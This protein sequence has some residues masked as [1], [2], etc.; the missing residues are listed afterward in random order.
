MKIKELIIRATEELKNNNVEDANLK[1]RILLSYILKKDKEYLIINQD[2]FVKRES[3]NEYMNKLEEIEEGM[4]LQY[5]TKSQEFMKLNFYVDEN[6][7]IPR[8]DTEILVEEVIDILNDNESLNILDMCTG[9]GAIAISIA[10]YTNNAS[11]YASDISK[12]ALEIAKKNARKN[13]V[14]DKI[15]FIESNLFENIDEIKFDIIISNPPY[16]KT[17]IIHTLSKEVKREPMIALDGGKD[18]LNFY[19][20]IINEAST[21]LKNKGYLCLEIGFDQKE[22]VI[23]LIDKTN[24]YDKIYSKKDLAGNDR[25]VIAKR[26]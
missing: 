23:D 8:P 2:E 13:K 1:A 5:I 10:K 9:S 25:I 24:E 3:I 17:N 20:K 7:L 18:G 6:V 4:P 16:I 11:I 15:K 21:F 19:R 26:R 22:A 14:E 12:K